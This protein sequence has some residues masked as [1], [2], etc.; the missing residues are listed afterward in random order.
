MGTS[1]SNYTLNNF[2][3]TAVDSTSLKEIIEMEEPDNFTEN[4]NKVH[5]QSK[6]KEILEAATRLLARRRQQLG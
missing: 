3:S 2:D 4:E 1:A 5:E 6:D